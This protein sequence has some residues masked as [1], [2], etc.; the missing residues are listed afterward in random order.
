MEKHESAQNAREWIEQFDEHVYLKMIAS[1]GAS[2]ALTHLHEQL[3]LWEI[4]TFEGKNGFEPH[5]WER[6]HSIRAFSRRLWQLALT[7]PEVKPISLQN[8]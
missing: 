6:L 2:K 7:H 5:L 3:N 4:E 1:E 8:E